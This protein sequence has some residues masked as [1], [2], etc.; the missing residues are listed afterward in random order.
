[1]LAMLGS[2]AGAEKRSR[3]SVWGVW[4]RDGGDMA[5]TPGGELRSL[6][7]EPCLQGQR[8]PFPGVRQICYP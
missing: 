1:M 2:E 4:V 3:G 7:Q 8:C 6:T 5:V